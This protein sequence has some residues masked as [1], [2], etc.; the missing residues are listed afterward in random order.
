MIVEKVVFGLQTFSSLYML[1]IIWFVQ[2]V[3]Y[4]LFQKI[5]PA[6]FLIYHQ[7]HIRMTGF[8]IAPVMLLE[9]F[10]SAYLYLRPDII[11]GRLFALIN[12]ATV[13]LLW[14]STFAVQV[15]L[16]SKL[17][18]EHSDKT[19]QKLTLTNWFRTILWTLRAVLLFYIF[20][21]V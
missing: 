8:V 10:S 1:G 4:P 18:L 7:T 15:P 11:G 21:F 3:H 2:L 14:I 13:A 6:D 17:S 12:L 16:H 19:I 9:L 20:L 5:R